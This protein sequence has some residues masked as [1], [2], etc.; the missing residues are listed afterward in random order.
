VA[1]FFLLPQAGDIVWCRFP[2]RGLPAPGPKA[3]PAL[4]IDIGQLRDEPAAEVIYGTS[5]KLDRLFP[6]EFPITPED[7]DAFV[8]SGLSYPTKFDTARSL[9][10]PYNDEWFAV[11]PGAPHGQIPKLG[12]LHP[13]LVRRAKAAFN[14]GRR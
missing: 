6:G 9:Y 13:S 2:Q 10:L 12:V 14:A 7:G 8:A 5:Q 1:R 4:V 11:A 3:R